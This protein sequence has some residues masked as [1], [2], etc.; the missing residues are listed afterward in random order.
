MTCEFCGQK[1]KSKGA[2]STHKY[3]KHGDRENKWSHK[4][5]ETEATLCPICQFPCATEKALS[6]HLWR[7]HPD[8]EGIRYGFKIQ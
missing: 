2:L 5:K 4:P 8:R 1:C 6:T 7:K 3:R